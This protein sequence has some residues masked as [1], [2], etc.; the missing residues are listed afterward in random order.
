MG[1]EALSR[2]A[3]FSSFVDKSPIACRTIKENIELLSI[4]KQAEVFC[5]PV[6]RALE[7]FKRKQRSFALIF[8]DPPYGKE[9]LPPILDKIA[10]WKLLQPEGK[11]FAEESAKSIIA[12]SPL[13]Q[14]VSKRQYGDSAL[15]EYGYIA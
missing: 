4:E 12:P 10:E 8:I 14:L 13:L 7:I 1:I 9:F 5:L 6:E 11:I 3:K 15:L 2:G